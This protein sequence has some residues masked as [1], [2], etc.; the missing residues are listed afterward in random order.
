[1]SERPI[2]LDYMATTPIDTCYSRDAVCI[3]GQMGIS[4]IQHRKTMNMA[5]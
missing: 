2:Y 5:R 3:W 4:V 1:M